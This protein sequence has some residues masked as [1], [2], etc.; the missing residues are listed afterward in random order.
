[1]TNHTTPAKSAA[2]KAAKKTAAAKPLTTDERI[3]QL[4]ES[5]A[6]LLLQLKQH[7][8]HLDLGDEAEDDDLVGDDASDSDGDDK[9]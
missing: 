3:T 7:G 6:A 4:E 5:H 8:I 9:E 1:M 2:K